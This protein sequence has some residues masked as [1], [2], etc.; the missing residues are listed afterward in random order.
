MH[1][2]GAF[3]DNEFMHKNAYVSALAQIHT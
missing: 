1:N 3:S 2:F